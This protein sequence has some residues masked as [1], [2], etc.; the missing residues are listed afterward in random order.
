MSELFATV[1]GISLTTGAL[2]ALL[3]LLSPLTG[4]RYAAKWRFWIWAVLALRLL[5]PINPIPE[6][7]PASV[8][9]A[10]VVQAEPV[11]RPTTVY[12]RFEFTIPENLTEPIDVPER[13]PHS[14]KQT[15]NKLPKVTPLGVI[16]VVWAAGSLICFAA[17]TVGFLKPRLVLPDSEYSEEQLGF[18]LR[19]E[20]IHYRRKDVW[21]KL[22]F[23]LAVS[24]HWFNPVIWIMR[25][26]ADIDMELSVD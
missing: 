14:E 26:R 22:L 1:L 15:V 21:F 20:L 17:Q 16:T 23:A 24:V 19:H 18:I 11:Q 7:S 13:A 4:R 9:K 6:R 10:P 2:A 5:I 8:E 12:P 3:M 25:R